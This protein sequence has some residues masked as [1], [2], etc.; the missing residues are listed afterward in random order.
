MDIRLLLISY[1]TLLHYYWTEA[2]SREVGTN[3]VKGHGAPLGPALSTG[4]W[5]AREA[6]DLPGLVPTVDSVQSAR[7]ATVIR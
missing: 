6:D 1:A 3:K 4:K 2:A 5:I 7:H